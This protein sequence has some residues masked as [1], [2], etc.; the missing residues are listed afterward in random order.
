[1]AP[2]SDALRRGEAAAGPALDRLIAAGREHFGR[3]GYAGTSL[4]AVVAAAGVTKGSL[5]HHFKGKADLFEAVFRQRAAELSEQVAAA[6]LPERDP[7]QAAYAGVRAYLDGSQEAAVER[8]MLL[9]GPSVLG[10]ERV[11]E[12]EAEYG[13]ALIKT[14]IGRLVDAGEIRRPDVDVLAHLLFG[15]ITEGV[16]LVTRSPDPSAARRTVEREIR[17]L[18]D[19]LGEPA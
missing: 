13:L 2:I 4:D 5:Y 11:R 14:S 10:W 9:D 16:L 15:A 3:D 19:G 6:S 12:I 18:V 7:W 1:M 8:I 17:R